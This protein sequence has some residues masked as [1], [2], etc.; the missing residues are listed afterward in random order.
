MSSLQRTSGLARFNW[1]LMMRNRTTMLYAFAVPL[2]PLGMLFLIDGDARAANAGSAVVGVT[3]VMALLFPGYYNLLSMFVTRRDEL[4]LKRLRT[5]EV[6]DLELIVSMALPGA[7]ITGAIAVLAIPVTMLAGYDLPLNIPLLAVGLGLA[8]VTFAALALWT[9]GWTRTAE[10]AQLTSGPVMLLAF[11]GFL[12]PSLP[13]RWQVWAGMLPG[14]AVD[15]LV[16]IGW[17]GQ[18]SLGQSPGSLDV[19][20][21]WS[22]AV[23]SLAV[24]SGWAFLAGVLA[25]VSLR[26]EP[27]T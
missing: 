7:W 19:A 14:A 6:G 18:R 1:R 27:R 8:V 16:R 26:W 4:V 22:E 20:R 2:L 23:P 11:A 17:F 12:A 9:A 25:L 21:S 10:S 5:G 3:M 24:L 13:D 15:E